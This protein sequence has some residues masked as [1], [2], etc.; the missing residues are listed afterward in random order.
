[1]HHL[2]KHKKQ[3]GNLES[4]NLETKNKTKKI[5]K[6]GKLQREYGNS[7]TDSKKTM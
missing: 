1:M 7:L 6:S 5:N 2:K 4:V 3:L